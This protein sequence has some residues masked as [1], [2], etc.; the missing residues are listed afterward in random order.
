MEFKLRGQV[1][2]MYFSV[3]KDTMKFYTSSI[4][5]KNNNIILGKWQKK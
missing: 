1:I 2:D 5:T 4:K 3:M